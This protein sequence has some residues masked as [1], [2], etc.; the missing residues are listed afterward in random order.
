VTKSSIRVRRADEH[1]DPVP[2]PAMA[3]CTAWLNSSSPGGTMRSSQEDGVLG[4]PKR[5]SAAPSSRAAHST[6]SR[7]TSA[8]SAGTEGCRLHGDGAL[9]VPARADGDIGHDAHSPCVHIRAR[10]EPPVRP[11]IT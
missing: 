10:S 9:R 11:C 4:G 1:K 6:R 2:G 5:T 7:R 3:P 8:F